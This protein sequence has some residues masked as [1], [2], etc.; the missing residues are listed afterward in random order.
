MPGDLGGAIAS[1]RQ[2]DESARTRTLNSRH[3]AEC[4]ALRVQPCLNIV[5][6]PVQAKLSSLR[7]RRPFCP[8]ENRSDASAKSLE[9]VVNSSSEDGQEHWRESESELLSKLS[10]DLILSLEDILSMSHTYVRTLYKFCSVQLFEPIFMQCTS[11]AN[12]VE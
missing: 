3:M 10:P 2:S 7:T 5:F 6:S 1:Q 4:K 8:A 12:A 9:D 11:A